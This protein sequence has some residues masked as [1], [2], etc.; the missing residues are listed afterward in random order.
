MKKEN[1]IVEK[2]E[3]EIRCEVIYTRIA[4]RFL[5][6]DEKVKVTKN[7][8]DFELFFRELDDKNW[9]L[10]TI[11]I[12]RQAM[13]E[14]RISKFRNEIES[15]GHICSRKSSESIKNFINE[16]HNNWVNE[17]K[18][19]YELVR[20]RYN[21]DGSETNINSAKCELNIDAKTWHEIHHPGPVLQ[22]RPITIPGYMTTKN[23]Q[24]TLQRLIDKKAEE[25]ISQKLIRESISTMAKNPKGAFVI[26]ATALEVGVK[27]FI[28]TMTNENEWLIENLPSPPIV[29]ILSEYIPTICTDFKLSEDK[30]SKLK[31]LINRRNKL[32]HVG[33]FNL[34]KS[35]LLKSINLIYDI[36][37]LFEIKKGNNWAKCYLED[38]EIIK[39]ST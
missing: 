32:V 3:I 15:S 17:T 34:D 9:E 33:E 10:V 23:L 19:I 7:G 24:S 12:F 29:K 27:E 31:T 25:P 26:A 4:I 13:R 38:K 14:K 5:D 35:Q 18:E 21:F 11:G 30:I 37:I 16:N 6:F 1:N 8:N 36:L 39:P 20:W 22:I 28:L 2:K